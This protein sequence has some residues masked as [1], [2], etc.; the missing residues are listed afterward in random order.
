MEPASS[1]THVAP[2]SA[3]EGDNGTGESKSFY[4]WLGL[5]IALGL[6]VRLIYAYHD[7]WDSGIGGDSAYYHY[8]AN[9]LARGLG[10]V[11]PWSWALRHT[12]VHAG[13]EHP[14]LYTMYL[15]IPSWLGF[16][17]YHEHMI[18]GCILGSLT[19]GVVGLAGRAVAGARVGIVA[20]LIAAVYVNLWVN[21]PL[22]LSETITT[23]VLAFA[24]LFAYRFWRDPSWRNASFFGLS[25]GFA[26]L[27]RA[28]IALYLPIVAIPL[29]IGA[30]S[31]ATKERIQRF[32][33]IVLL[34]AIPVVPWVGYNLSRFNQPVT[35]SDGGDF[36]LANTYCKTTF[37]GPRVGWWDLRCVPDRWAIPGD[38]SDA[39]KVFRK[40]GLDYL[41]DHLTRFPVVLLARFGRMWE[42]YQPF[43]KLKWD[44]FE[45]GRSPPYVPKVALA[46]FYV[47]VLLAIGGLVMLRRRKVIIYPLVALAV[48]ATFAGMLAF[49]GTRYRA[50]AELAIVIAA[51][52]PIV[53]LWNRWFPPRRSG[54]T[55][56]T[57]DSDSPGAAPAGDAA[58]LPEPVGS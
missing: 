17:T 25:C 14:P 49:G 18:A 39:A 47:L 15:A 53:A 24:V 55:T 16:D 11:D 10:F 51:A 12:G 54:T 5:A 30:R 9:A 4:I 23:F 48:T 42:L 56:G 57:A 46:Q 8:Q 19:C 31:L 7:K 1:P 40:Q 33:V 26:M 58:R 13:A 6:A 34:A 28:E 41:G 2:G 36:T 43:Q 45:Q 27:A 29:V 44:A 38:E 52:V 50:P 21:D 37:Y 3:S 22:V 32:G 20:A 35:L